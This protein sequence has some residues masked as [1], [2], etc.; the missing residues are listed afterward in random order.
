[1]SRF[2]CPQGAED[3]G[4]VHPPQKLGAEGLL[5]GVQHPLPVPRLLRAYR[6]AR[7]L[8]LTHPR[9]QIGGHDDDRVAEVHPPPRGVGERAVVHDLE[10]D[11]ED[12]GVSLPQL[13]EEHHGVGVPPHPLGELSSLLVADIPGRRTDQ[14]GDA[15][16]F[17]ILRHIQ[18][19]Q[20]LFAPEK[21]RRQSAGQLGL[22]D[23][24]L[25]QEDEGADGTAGI[26]QTQPPP[27]DGSRHY[28]HR[29]LLADD[30]G[31]QGLLQPQ[32][33]FPL[34]LQQTGNGDPRPLGH[35]VSDMGFGD[36]LL[37]VR[38]MGSVRPGLFGGLIGRP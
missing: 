17:H 12:I 11:V 35:N 7:R 6:K 9:S 3:H 26:L 1:M 24:R 27:T 19:Y 21:S 20:G 2:V 38:A 13:V 15:V 5:Q 18:A 32:E 4:L 34:A 14:T 37:T 30:P 29:L 10:Q 36:R 25:P 31:L 8:S 23:P 28:P 33:P 22:A 16:L